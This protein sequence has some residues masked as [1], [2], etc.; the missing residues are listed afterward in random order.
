M[1]AATTKSVPIRLFLSSQDE[2]ISIEL[3][4]GQV[5]VLFLSHLLR[6]QFDFLVVC[7]QIYRGILESCQPNMNCRL[8]DVTFTD[9][10][11]AQ[12]EESFK[13]LDSV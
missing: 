10:S 8:V 1:S 11:V 5:R 3:H 13:K 12:L 9:P 2:T 6:T 7:A 4:N